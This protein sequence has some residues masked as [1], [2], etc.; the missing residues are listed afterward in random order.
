MTD[1]I[2][3]GAGDA[4][5]I[6]TST[7][8]LTLE[9]AAPEKF[10]DIPD[11]LV[12][13]LPN[14]EAASI[15]DLEQY[16]EF[17]RRKRG[18]ITVSTTASLA[19]Y[20]NVHREDGTTVYADENAFTVTAVINDHSKATPDHRDHRA[21]LKL[22]T[23]PAYDRWVGAHAKLMTQVEF[24]QLIE[25]GQFEI[26]EPDG[27]TVLEIAQSMQATIGAEFRSANRLTD[28]RTQF[29]YTEEINAKAGAAGDL[30][31][32][33]KITL[34]FAPFNGAAPIT[35]DARLRYR[36][37]SGKLSLGLW[38]IR[39][40]E[41]IRASFQAEL[42]MLAEGTADITDGASPASPGLVALWGKPS[43]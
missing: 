43:A 42:D 16:A 15:V 6:I 24:A 36:M 29:Q 31:I 37:Q 27:A 10:T 9:A 17:P 21:V 3:G 26:V 40:V 41:A 12:Y 23:T 35:I 19:Q 38:L 39:H 34:Q 5:A 20:L 13:A 32:P 2:D 18:T 14:G 7:R 11:L 28:G 33:E 1:L 22:T 8:E 4:A 25:D 30:A